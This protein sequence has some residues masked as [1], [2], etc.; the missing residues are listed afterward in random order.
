MAEVKENVNA[1]FAPTKPSLGEDIMGVLE[2]IMRL[3][4]ISAQ[5]LFYKWESYCLKMGSEETTLDLATVRMFQKDVQDN[6]ERSHQ[7][8]H[9]ARGSERKPTVSATPRAVG[10]GDVFGMYEHTLYG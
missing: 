3:H 6:L 8:K 7:G 4:S 9:T 5:E 10:N 1:L 2:S